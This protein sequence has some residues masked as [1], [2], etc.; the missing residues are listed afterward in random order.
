MFRNLLSLNVL[1]LIFSAAVVN[2]EVIKAPAPRIEV[3]FVLD[4]TS[5]MTGLIE[6][7][8]QKIWSIANQMISA[9]PTP[10]LKVGLVAYRDRGDE[11]ITKVFD[12]SDDI[13]TVYANLRHF[14]AV[15]G[16]DG[17]ESVNQAMSEAVN[18]IHWS[19]DK[20]VLKLIFLVGDFPPHMDYQ[21]DVKY[22]QTCQDAVKKDIVINTVQCGNYEETTPVWQEIARLGE[23]KYVAIG[24]TGDMQIAATPM[25]AE[26]AELNAA[27]GSTVVSYGT[28]SKKDA[29]A[30]KMEAAASMA[31]PVAAERVA[32]NKATGKVVQGEGDL[33]ADMAEG[34][35]DLN[36]L[37]ENELPAAL[38][39]KSKEE[40][41]AY[42]QKQSEKRKELQSKVDELLKKRQHYVDQEQ[43]KLAGPG[44]S[45]DEKVAEMVKE[46][47]AKKG[48]RY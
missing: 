48:I 25:D 37:K 29:V 33:L 22:S 9:K 14:Q 27:L 47:A 15:G 18:K 6:G 46:E 36:S 4:T 40:Q 7:A 8:K 44:N 13:D 17:P 2:A 5:S 23:G 26:L 20:N 35:A 30:R 38:A 42:L 24:Q 32:Y 11:Y 41:K 3:T 34:K 19:T 43:K 12:L 45:F 28:V 31:A 39:G 1:V 16:G 21:D 10:N